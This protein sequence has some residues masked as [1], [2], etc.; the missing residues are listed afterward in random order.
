MTLAKFVVSGKFISTPVDTPV[1]S[2]LAV[3]AAHGGSER[4]A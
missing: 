1:E 2:C 4:G 3:K